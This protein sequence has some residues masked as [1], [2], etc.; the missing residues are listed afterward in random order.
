MA[1]HEERRAL[2][3]VTCPW[4]GAEPG[5]ICFIPVRARTATER[6]KPRQTAVRS[7]DGGCHNARWQAALSRDAKV[8]VTALPETRSS[9]A[10]GREPVAAGGVER[11]W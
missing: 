6:S 8:I 9:R 11:P 10:A 2:L 5:A 7:L 4:C 1:T 3:A